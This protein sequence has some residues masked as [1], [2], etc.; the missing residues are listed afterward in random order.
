MTAFALSQK[1]EGDYSLKLLQV[2][3]DNTMAEV[4]AAAAANS[5]GIHVADQPGKVVRARA[6]GSEEPYPPDMR[7]ADTGL[8]HTDTVE[9]YFEAGQS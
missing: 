2:D 1:F 7:L 9:F 4:A 8:G 3:S 5:V 6:E